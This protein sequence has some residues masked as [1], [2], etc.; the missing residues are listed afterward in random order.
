MAKYKIGDTFH[1][2][3][4]DYYDTT[5]ISEGI[6]CIDNIESDYEN[7][8]V[9]IFKHLNGNVPWLAVIESRLDCADITVRYL[10][11]INTNSALKVLYGQV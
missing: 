9:L 4:F 1:I 6:V 11:N 5:G 7:E 8:S 2:L 10:G 3:V